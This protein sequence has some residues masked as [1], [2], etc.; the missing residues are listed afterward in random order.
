VHDQW[1]LQRAVEKNTLG[2]P[3]TLKRV[4]EQQIDDYS[5]T[6][7]QILEAASLMGMTFSSA[8]VAAALTQDVE[9]V[10]ACCDQLV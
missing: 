9:V 7:R 2:V 4:I 1:I 3:D 6:T 5:D 10:E 8:A